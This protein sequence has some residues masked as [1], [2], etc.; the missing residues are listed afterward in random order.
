MD[1]D[2]MFDDALELQWE[3]MVRAGYSKEQIDL[4]K[5][6][7]KDKENAR[8]Y[9][10]MVQQHAWEFDISCDRVDVHL[11][12]AR[13]LDAIC[14]RS[15]AIEILREAAEEDHLFDSRILM[16]LAKLLFRDDQKD[17][18]LFYCQSIIKAY[19]DKQAGEQCEEGAYISVEDAL[20][21]Y[22][23]S[24]WIKIHDDNH[25]DAYKI[26]SE[27][28]R[29]I[30]SCPVLLKQHRKREYW[31]QDPAHLEEWLLQVCDDELRRILSTI[32]LILSFHDCIPLDGYND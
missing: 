23:L 7:K 24:G 4:V 31:D 11:K 5:Q 27:G 3:T 15:D 20:S 22:Y 16:S 10:Y 18:S 29:A 17:L 13:A 28:H 19:I 1:G 21:S 30:P 14:R 32:H 12:L 8:I 25:T 9:G 2:E 26:W 6:R